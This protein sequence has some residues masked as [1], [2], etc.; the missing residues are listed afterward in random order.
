MVIS[1]R[2]VFGWAVNHVIRSAVP[3]LVPFIVQE[4]G[5][6]NGEAAVLLSAFFQ[7]YLLTQLPG[8]W[9]AQK[10]GAKAVAQLNLA[11]NTALL[12]LPMLAGRGVRALSL[13]LCLIGLCQGP[14]VP[15]VSVLQRNWLPNGPMRAWALTFVSMGGRLARL[16]AAGTGPLLADRFGWRVIAYLYGT[17]AAAF[18]VTFTVVASEQPALELSLATE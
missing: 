16:V 10:W 15:S 7:G 9:A 17:L 6:D 13:C 11:G 4:F 5:F 18:A 14:L 12:L 3:P 2:G 1:A 8:G